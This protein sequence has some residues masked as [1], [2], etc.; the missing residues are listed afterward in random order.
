LAKTWKKGL[1]ISYRTFPL[2]A[3]AWGRK[4]KEKMRVDMH[5]QEEMLKA[6]EELTSIE[7][8]PVQ[9]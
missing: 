2:K 1:V 9:V 3:K 5:F 8:F 7:V 4:N 6:Q